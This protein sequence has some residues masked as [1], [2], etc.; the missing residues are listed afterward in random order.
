MFSFILLLFFSPANYQYG[1]RPS[2]VNPKFCFRFAPQGACAETWLFYGLYTSKLFVHIFFYFIFLL[3]GVLGVRAVLMVA[4]AYRWRRRYI[5]GASLMI[6]A[7]A[8]RSA[9]VVYFFQPF[10]SS[11]GKCDENTRTLYGSLFST[12]LFFP[13]R[14]S[15]WRL[16]MLLPFSFHI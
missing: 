10:H 1:H 4:V 7:R 14:G 5:P 8:S 11:L 6:M 15:R 16:C 13:F 2:S 3:G 9:T 12:N